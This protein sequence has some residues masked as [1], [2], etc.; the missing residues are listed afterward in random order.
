MENEPTDLEII[1]RIQTG[2]E[3]VL[4]FCYKKHFHMVTQ[5]VFRQ[6]ASNDIAKDVFQ[7]TLIALWKNASKKDFLLTSKLSTYLCQIAK[8]LWLKEFHKLSMASRQKENLINEGLYQSQVD[9]ELTELDRE[10]GLNIIKRVMDQLP[11]SYKTLLSLLYFEGLSHEEI[12]QR[13][14]L[15]NKDVVKT[16]KWKAINRM[17][18]LVE[19]L[20]L[21]KGLKLFLAEISEEG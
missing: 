10:I 4:A 3:S 19:E 17:K 21:R 5:I 6:G 18:Q 14:E 20:D 16:M 9:R 11:V 1:R 13:M 7:D 2:D 12:M 8:N 15:G